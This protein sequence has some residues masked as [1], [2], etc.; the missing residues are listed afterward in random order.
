MRIRERTQGQDPREHLLRP[1]AIGRVD[2]G[3]VAQVR[4]A[5]GARL[6]RR[7]H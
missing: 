5:V 7:A 4:Q 2:A 1:E 3:L 6:G